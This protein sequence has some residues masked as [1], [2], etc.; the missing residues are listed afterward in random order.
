MNIKN[1]V[2]DIVSNRNA[3]PDLAVGVVQ[4]ILAIAYC[5]FLFHKYKTVKTPPDS[6]RLVFVAAFHGTALRFIHSYGQDILDGYLRQLHISRYSWLH[7]T[8]YLAWRFSPALWII[9]IVASPIRWMFWLS[10]YLYTCLA[11]AVHVSLLYQL[12]VAL[13][14]I[15]A[16]RLCI[17]LYDL[18]TV[19]S[20][21][22]F[23][24]SRPDSPL[25]HLEVLCAEV[26][27]SPLYLQASAW[28]LSG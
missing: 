22:C 16:V 9:W 21:A 7:F 26:A 6:D 27:F 15:L 20:S 24:A 23:C 14:F 2:D 1:I 10:S 13:L 4:C 8:D 3:R 19:S 11:A 28:E 25:A 12:A 18:W 17:Y 5:A